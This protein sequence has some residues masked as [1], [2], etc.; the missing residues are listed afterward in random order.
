MVYV[1]IILTFILLTV[2]LKLIVITKLASMYRHDIANDMQ[3]MKGYFALEK[4]EL[5]KQ[6]INQID[7][8]LTTYTNLSNSSIIVK[9]I[10]LLF[11][12]GPSYSTIFLNTSIKN[13][14]SDFVYN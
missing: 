4:P 3:L 5:V 14:F 12:G 7:E 11:Q 10:Y 8:K 9:I 13:S 1:V 2:S 6:T